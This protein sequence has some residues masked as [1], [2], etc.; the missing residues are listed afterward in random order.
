VGL[1]RDMAACI[2]PR[3]GFTPHPLTIH[4][5]ASMINLVESAGHLRELRLSPAKTDP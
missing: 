4:A 2:S 1:M 5:A 3:P